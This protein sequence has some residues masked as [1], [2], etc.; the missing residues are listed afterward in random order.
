MSYRVTTDTRHYN[1]PENNSFMGAL[2]EIYDELDKVIHYEDFFEL[3]F[4]VSFVASRNCLVVICEFS[5]NRIQI[6]LLLP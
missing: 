2:T 6:V 1:K 3:W 4:Y 5:V